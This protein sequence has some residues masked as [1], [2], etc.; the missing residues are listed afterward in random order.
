MW[1]GVC[2]H[3]VAILE[4]IL[5]TDAAKPQYFEKRPYLKATDVSHL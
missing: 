1:P 5:E 4:W 3:G 2:C